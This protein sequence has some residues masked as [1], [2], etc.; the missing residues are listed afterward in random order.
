MPPPNAPQLVQDLH[1]AY[2]ARTGLEIAYNIGR[3]NVW[4]EW[5]SYSNWTWTVEDL[6]RVIGW[7]KVKISRDE[8]NAGALRFANLI[9]QP[10]R[11]EE[12][13]QF[14][15]KEFKRPLGGYRPKPRRQEAAPTAEDVPL[16]AAEAAARWRQEFGRSS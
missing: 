14:A 2:V 13:L 8:R 1:A 4:R 6:A 15:R 12:D 3:E 16:D 11:F 5:C 7:L 10:D 9:G